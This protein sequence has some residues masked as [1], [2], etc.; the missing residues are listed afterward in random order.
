MYEPIPPHTFNIHGFWKHEQ[1]KEKGNK[2]SKT[3]QN[4]NLKKVIQEKK[5]QMNLF[6]QNNETS[7][8]NGKRKK[9]KAN[10]FGNMNTIN[11]NMFSTMILVLLNI[12]I[13]YFPFHKRSILIKWY[14]PF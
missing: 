14:L 6:K 8:L 9:A 4:L 13:Q 10:L 3:P 2:E 5:N 12:Q 7:K 11:I 1:Y